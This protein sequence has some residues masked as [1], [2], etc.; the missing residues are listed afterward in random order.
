M[1]TKDL[2][3]EKQ[4]QH[5]EVHL[6]SGKVLGGDF[7][8]SGRA[9]G[10]LGSETLMDVF[11]DNGRSFLPFTERESGNF[12]LLNKEHIVMV[13]LV[14]TDPRDVLGFSVDATIPTQQVVFYH[15]DD[16]TRLKGDAYVG[17]LHPDNRRL[18]DLLN[19]ESSF[20]LLMVDERCYLV[21]KQQMHFAVAA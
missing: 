16:T 6:V 2:R 7:F 15:G 17:D 1:T 3:I 19:H 11:N 5:A 12:H 4:G 14:G 20:L 10:R 18:T 8:L 21:H 9:R 13:E